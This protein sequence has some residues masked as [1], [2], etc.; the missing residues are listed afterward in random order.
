MLY[1]KHFSP[2]AGQGISMEVFI[3]NFIHNFIKNC[4]LF[5]RIILSKAM[6][7]KYSNCQHDAPVTGAVVLW[8]QDLHR[9]S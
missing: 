7:L 8:S 6:S 3:V 5:W 4:S 1:M 2:R 9:R